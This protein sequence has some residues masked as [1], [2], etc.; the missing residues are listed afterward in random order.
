MRFLTY[1]KRDVTKILKII[2]DIETMGDII[3]YMATRENHPGER[4][5]YSVLDLNDQN[6]HHH[7]HLLH[8][9]R[10]YYQKGIIER[11]QIKTDGSFNHSE[12]LVL[13][14]TISKHR[15][16]TCDQIELNQCLYNRVT[17]SQFGSYYLQECLGPEIPYST[18]RK[19]TQSSSRLNQSWESNGKLYRMLSKKSLPTIKT[20]LIDRNG[21]FC[22]R[23]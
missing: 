18:I 8:D 20:E 6:N 1:A 19:S 22:L 17:F 5:A 14:S 3:Y 2:N 13:K 21:R 10:N 7:H 16:Y 12:L 4:H 15:C 11:H 9:H 23:G